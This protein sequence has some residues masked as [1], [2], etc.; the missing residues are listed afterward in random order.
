MQ[1]DLLGS[2]TNNI[3][4]NID[5]EEVLSHLGDVDVKIPHSGYDR[6]CVFKNSGQTIV[7]NAWTLLTFDDEKYD[8][9]DLHDNVTNNSRLTIQKDGLYQIRANIETD[10]QEKKSYEIKIFKNGVEI[11]HSHIPGYGSK[12]SSTLV[13][14]SVVPY[15]ELVAGDYVEVQIRHDNATGAFIYED[16]TYFEIERR[17]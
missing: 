12:N 4:T 2:K 7:A 11:P 6:A 5:D 14:H 3:W 15:S 1:D 13:L 9:N 10:A 16:S 17:Y 8:T